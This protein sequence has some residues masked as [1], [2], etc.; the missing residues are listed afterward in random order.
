[1]K[2]D[3]FQYYFPFIAFAHE[4]YLHDSHKMLY[5][6]N[7]NKNKKGEFLWDF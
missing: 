5:N 3:N 4:I 1:M 6:Q 7:C 2:I